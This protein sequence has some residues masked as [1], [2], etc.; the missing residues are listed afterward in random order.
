M[1][2][3]FITIP[4][5]CSTATLQRV[6]KHNCDH[7]TLDQACMQH[8]HKWN[9]NCSPWQHK[10]NLSSHLV[11]CN[12]SICNLGPKISTLRIVI[13]D[14][15][16]ITDKSGRVAWDELSTNK[17]ANTAHLLTCDVVVLVY[18]NRLHGTTTHHKSCLSRPEDR[19]PGDLTVSSSS[20]LPNQCQELR[21][22]I[23][24]PVQ[25]ATPCPKHNM[26]SITRLDPQMVWPTLYWEGCLRTCVVDIRAPLLR[27]LLSYCLMPGND[28]R[29]EQGNVWALSGAHGAKW[30]FRKSCQKLREI[31]DENA[32][33]SPKI[34]TNFPRDRILCAISNSLNFPWAGAYVSRPIDRF[35]WFLSL[36]DYTSY[37]SESL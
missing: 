21:L 25:S 19:C 26:A 36:K 27:Y 17:N 13:L 35:N 12:S 5:Y 30:P 23:M 18:W 32:F 6:S 11:C 4:C 16:F 10:T 37:A 22:Q 3:G 1:K 9:G 15:S 28:H 34:V 31:A 14:I 33:L 8:P 2:R 29:L 20:W 7:R 24:I